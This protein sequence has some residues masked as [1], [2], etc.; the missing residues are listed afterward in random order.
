MT[1]LPGFSL[2]QNIF[3]T[4]WLSLLL[5]A[6]LFPVGLIL[7]PWWGWENGPLENTQVVIL[8]I[9]LVISWFAARHNRSNRKFRNLW[10]WLTPFW[11]LVIGRELSWGRVFYPVAFGPNG[12]EFISLHQLWYGPF[13][14][15]AVAV[16]IIAMVTGIIFSSPLKYMRHAKLPLLDIIIL[17]FTALLASACDKGMVPFFD[18]QQEVLEEWAE[19]TAYWSMLSIVTIVGLRKR[20]EYTLGKVKKAPSIHHL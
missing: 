19:L 18:P 17:I 6:S 2:T 20:H 10:L 4:T 1:K 12:P 16:T 15:P 14:K 9:G 11:L 8:G 13:V 3:P 7:P 5:T